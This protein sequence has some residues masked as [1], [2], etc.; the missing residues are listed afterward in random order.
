MLARP[1]GINDQSEPLGSSG[2]RI[3][4]K[5]GTEDSRKSGPQNLF[6]LSQG[7]GGGQSES[8]FH[9]FAVA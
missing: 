9:R 7:F 8:Q 2:D 3:R 5:H 1:S 4:L 6:L